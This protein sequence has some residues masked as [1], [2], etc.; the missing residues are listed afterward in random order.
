MSNGKKCERAL[1]LLLLWLTGCAADGIFY[2]P[3]R[4][5]YA[6]PAAL[7]L[8]HELVSYPSLNGKKLYALY[9]KTDQPP[10]GT[11]VF[12]HGNFGNV[13]NHFPQAVFLI[14]QGFDVL[15]FDYQ[16]FGGSEGKPSP[17]KTI[18]DGLASVRY[19]KE[20]LRGKGVVLF[21]QSIGAAVAAVTAARDTSVRAVVLESGFTTYRAITKDVMKRGWLTWPFSFFLPAL[22]VRRRDDPVDNVAAIAPRPLLIL[23]GTK[24]KV[25]PFRMSEALF[26]RAQEPK[27]FWAV[28]GADH[29]QC[30]RMGGEEYKRRIGEFF[31]EALMN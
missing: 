7:G 20:H 21:G 29:L 15:S 10:K 31:T 24:D 11:V 18:E 30:Q 26:A 27:T 6:D 17:K 16:G 5:L 9:F 23:H 3:N 1:I 25:I 28:E 22:I 12:F 2:Y 4:R 14:K 8:N 13:S 19:A